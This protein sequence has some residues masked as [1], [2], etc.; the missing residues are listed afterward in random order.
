MNIQALQTVLYL[1]KKYSESVIVYAVIVYQTNISYSN[2]VPSAK[3]LQ[4]YGS[5]GR[6]SCVS[7]L[8]HTP[9]DVFCISLGR[10]E[11]GYVVH[12]PKIT[13]NCFILK[14]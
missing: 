5:V 4:P 1:Y 12:N 6:V 14:F 9:W 10:G 3:H 13:K 2:G 8:F 11:R 7:R